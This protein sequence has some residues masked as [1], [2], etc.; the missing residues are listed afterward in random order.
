MPVLDLL[1]EAAL[2]QVRDAGGELE[3]LEAARDLAERVGADLAVLAGQ[4]RRDLLAML[5]DQ[6]ADAEHDLGALADAASRA[7]R[8]GGLRRGDRGIDLLDRCEVDL[9]ATWPVAGL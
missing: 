9:R 6:V 3:V 4:V 1:A 7:S 2:E 5:L 8:E